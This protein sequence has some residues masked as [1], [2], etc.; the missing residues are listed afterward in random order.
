MQKIAIELF[1]LLEE[2]TY[3]NMLGLLSHVAD[4]EALLLS[5]IIGEHVE[6]VEGD[7]IL[8][9]LHTLF[10]LFLMFVSLKIGTWGCSDL[11]G[12]ILVP[13]ESGVFAEKVPIK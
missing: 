2:V 6:K 8:K 9:G 12:N 7:A 11:T 10:T 4:V 1:Y 3:W 5:C 13:V